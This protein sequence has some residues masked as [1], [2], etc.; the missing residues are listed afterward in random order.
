MS[1]FFLLEDH[2][3]SSFGTDCGTDA[4]AFAVVEIDQN[5]SRLLIPGN[6]EVGTEEATNLAG[7]TL[8]CR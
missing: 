1:G 4:A 6:T 2:P 7:L 3:N 8:P 5:L